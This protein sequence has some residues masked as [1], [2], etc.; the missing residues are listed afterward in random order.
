MAKKSSGSVRQRILKLFLTNVGRVVT[1]EQIQQVARDPKT[2]KVPENWH[3]RLS[4]LRTD[5]GYNIQSFRDTQELRVSEYRL[6]SATPGPVAGKRVKI[7]APTWTEVRRRAGDACQWEEDGRRCGLRAGESDPVGG[8]TVK[9]TPDHKTPHSINPNINPDD[10][11]EWQALC[12]R[13]QVMKKNFWDHRTGKLNV[14]AIVQAASDQ[15]KRAVY[16]FLRS[17]FGE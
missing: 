9:L 5:Y 14:Y 12:G 7:A 15:D 4:E 2:K 6:V 3:Q 17:F 16:D 13:H 10:P 11:D 1:R 8:G